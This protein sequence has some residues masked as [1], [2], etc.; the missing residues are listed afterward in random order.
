MGFREDPPLNKLQ[1]QMNVLKIE[2]YELLNTRTVRNP[3]IYHAVSFRLSKTLPQQFEEWSKNTK[4][5]R[6]LGS[7][8]FANRTYDELGNEYKLKEIALREYV[9]QQI[10]KAEDDATKA[11]ENLY[12][13]DPTA[14]YGFV[15]NQYAFT[16]QELIDK[17]GFKNIYDIATQQIKVEGGKKFKTAAEFLADSDGV[18]EELKRRQQIMA[19][20]REMSEKSSKI[21]GETRLK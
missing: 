5:G 6:G 21:T 17:S 1:R 16:E 18:V 4:L 11:F 14:A 9:K 13:E 10:Q 15:R 2:E 7:D 20:A 8:L 3:S 19:F 12:R